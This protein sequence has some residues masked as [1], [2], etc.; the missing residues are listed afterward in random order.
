MLG[1]S[2]QLDVELIY[3]VHPAVTVESHE[4]LLAAFVKVYPALTV[5]TLTPDLDEHR[6]YYAF[7]GSRLEG[8][9]SAGKTAASFRDVK[10]QI[11]RELQI[12]VM[13][14]RMR[15]DVRT[16]RAVFLDLVSAENALAVAPQESHE[17]LFSEH[18]GR[19]VVVYRRI[20]TSAKD[21]FEMED[22][23]ARIGG[24]LV[25]DIVMQD[26]G[27]SPGARLVGDGEVRVI[28]RVLGRRHA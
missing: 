1:E 15:K 26:M 12:R 28:F 8:S 17:P 13:F 10:P 2:T 18:S 19:G 14:Q 4:R 23:G 6:Q 24:C 11:T 22:R 7:H 16:L 3:A 5:Q 25:K 27:R 21:L 9:A 20:S